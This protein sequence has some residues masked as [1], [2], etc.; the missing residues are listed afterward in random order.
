MEITIKHFMILAIFNQDFG[1]KLRIKSG[2][3][4]LKTTFSSISQKYCFPAKILWTDFQLLR[5][6]IALPKLKNVRL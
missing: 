6:A 5:T 3:L 4:V 2:N 1:H